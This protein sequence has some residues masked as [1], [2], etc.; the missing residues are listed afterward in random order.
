MGFSG[1]GSNVLLPHTH[2]G[3]VSQDGGPLNFAN[4]TQAQLNS[5]DTTYSD[6][7]HLQ[8]LAVGNPND[9]LT[10]SG[11]NLPAWVAPSAVTT[12]WTELSDTTAST[13]ELNSSVF[14]HYDNLD[15]WIIGANSSSQN[16]AVSFNDDHG[17]SYSYTTTGT[18]G[19]FGATASGD[20]LGIWGGN[21]AT[22]VFIHMSIWNI[23]DREPVAVWQMCNVQGTG[24]QTLVQGSGVGKWWTTT[25]ITS[26][27]KCQYGGVINQEPGARMIVYGANP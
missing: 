2:D 17:N 15:V 27:Q 7:S 22:P 9:V 24:S 20:E 19:G 8:Q 10:V 6:G 5:G 3:T 23:V 14:S 16:T 1:G 13:S 21:S 18:S 11:A 12:V 25:G 26:I 4:I